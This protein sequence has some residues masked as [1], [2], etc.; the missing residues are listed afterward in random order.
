[1]SEGASEPTDDGGPVLIDPH[2]PPPPPPQPEPPPESEYVIKR[3]PMWPFLV[4]L[5]LVAAGIL[6]AVAYFMTQPEPL[7]V[8]VAIDY[9]GEP[10]EGSKASA[11]FSDAICDKLKKVGFEPVKVGDPAVDKVLEKA[12]SPEEAAWKLKAAFVITGKL[13]P[14]VVEEKLPPGASEE[15]YFEAR[16]DADLEVRQIT[17]PKGKVST[18]HVSNWSGAQT[19][20]DAIRIVGEG[21]SDM[22]FDEVASRMME[23]PT[24]KDLLAGTDI[25]ALAQIQDAK[26]FVERRKNMLG[27]VA[28]R[29]EELEKTYTGT[30]QA[31]RP[32]KY[33]SRFDADDHLAGVGP[34]GVLVQTADVSPLVSP[35]SAELGE[36]IRLE[37]LEWR[38]AGDAAPRVVWKGYH[39]YSY[40]SCASSGSPVVFVEDL[41][42]RAKTIT[43]VV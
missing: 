29:Y 7:R 9:D 32:I 25:K 37:T 4:G 42:G 6:G 20:D 36:I 10:W 22:V 1:M 24:I 3:R 43:V 15:K 16:V 21:L 18:A 28:K 17:D 26:K 19:K 23:H 11:H 8:L 30:P 38:S 2:A 31:P 33:L 14:T 13:T 27:D 40:P 5:L 39:L 34:D 12:K 35:D 41:F